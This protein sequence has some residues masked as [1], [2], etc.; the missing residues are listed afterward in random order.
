VEAPSAKGPTGAP[1]RLAQ[2]TRIGKEK[3]GAMRGRPGG[4]RQGHLPGGVTG[5]DGRAS[6]YAFRELRLAC[7]CALCVDEWTGAPRLDPAT[8]PANV[9]PLDVKSVGRYALQFSWSDGHNSGI[10]TYDRLRSLDP[11]APARAPAK[12]AGQR[13]P[14]A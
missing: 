8:V 10:Y 5:R 4:G 12:P 14:R 1:G 3:R 13:L 2:E 9:R 7:P 11:T 6:R